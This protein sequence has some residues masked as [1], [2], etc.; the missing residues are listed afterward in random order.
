M[1]AFRQVLAVAM[2]VLLVLLV[3][4]GCLRLLGFA[5]TPTL[6]RFDP[7][8]GW[9]KESNASIRRRTAEFDVAFSTNSRGLREPESTRYETTAGR[10]RVLMVGD[11]FT[12]GYTV[13]E[14]AT[15]PRLLERRL[16]AEGRDIEVINAG[17]EGWSTDQE[18]LWLETEGWRYQPDIVVLQMYENDIFW[19]GQ[20]HYLHYPKP[21]LVE[22]MPLAKLGGELS[23]PGR[24]SWLVRSSALVGLIDRTLNPPAMPTLAGT[25]GL[26]AEWQI[27]LTEASPGVVE[28]AAALSAFAMLG[29]ELGFRPVVL[30]VPDKAQIDA[31]ARDAMAQ[32]IDDPRY[33]PNRPFRTMV[34]FGQVLG[35]PVVDP[36]KALVAASDD[37]RLAL[38]FE[39]DWHTN[40]L[41]NRV[42]AQSV[43]DVLAQPRLLG[44]PPKKV[45]PDLSWAEN[46]PL[47]QG[48]P[49]WPF[50]LGVFW[51]LLGTAFWRRFPGQGV[52]ASY[53]GVGALLGSVVAV[54]A[55]L[56]W[57]SGVLPATLGWL[58]PRV[59]ALALAGAIVWTL[60]RRLP[61]MVEVFFTF[62][63]RGQW[64]LLPAL[65]GLLS[66]GG[67]LVVA[68]ASPWLAPFIYTLF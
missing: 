65:A 2:S 64:Y 40:A 42:I 13:A 55:G 36:L 39:R 61:V 45:A 5:P 41:G 20:D 24:G 14:E 19:N 34:L 51:L 37:S 44:A 29:A 11:S 26:P 38:Y 15:I 67:L 3:I 32:L 6:N 16:R 52:L 8:L 22:G 59:A 18:V 43:A 68:A 48:P 35:V 4:E 17:T 62:V 7:R 47:G 1:K 49:V 57:L 56:N 30:V 28:T 53:G 46:N 9:T 25:R 60:R 21:R 63:R 10:Q 12:L 54:L 31:K 58:L 33:D 27:R 66:I 23:D 50:A